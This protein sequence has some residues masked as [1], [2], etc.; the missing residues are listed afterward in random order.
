[1][2][3]YILKI[4]DDSLIM[5]QRL[6]EWCG[7]GP[8]LEEDIAIIN[9]ALD[10]L[11]Q[12]NLL[13]N[14]AVKHWADGRSVDDFAMK[15]VE[16]EYL[17][18]QLVELPNGDYANTILKTYFFAV[19]QNVL[20]EA[21]SNSA[22]EDIKAVALKSLKEVRY[23]YTHTETWMRVFAQGTDESKNRLNAAL[24][25]L[26]EYTGGLFD[27]VEDEQNFGDLGLI[28]SS[29]TIKEAWMNKIAAD[30]AKFGLAIPSET[31]M[32]K[33]SRKGIHTEWFG[34]ILCELQYMQRT[35]PD[36]AW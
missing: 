36:C 13:Y 25:N 17:N 31:W 10:Q 6:S 20:Y 8:Y 2:K 1:M 33:G 7:K 9:I 5:G 18:A 14:I 34:Y 28:P 24:E 27:E 16:K 15:R 4:A 3:N 30:F 12:A 29:Q 22:D 23:H 11:G 19:Y 32:Q 26:W 21:L 35:Y